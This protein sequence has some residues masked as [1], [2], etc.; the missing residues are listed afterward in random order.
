MRLAAA[1]ASAS[2]TAAR[3]AFSR[4]EG[5][6]RP[7][8]ASSSSPRR[9]IP[10]AAHTRASTG[11]RPSRTSWSCTRKGTRRVVICD[12]SWMTCHPE[13]SEGSAF[14]AHSKADSSGCALRMTSLLSIDRKRFP[15]PPEI[16]QVRTYGL[17]LEQ[18]IH[19]AKLKREHSDPAGLQ[20]GEERPEPVALERSAALAKRRLA[21]SVQNDQRKALV[22][23]RGENGAG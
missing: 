13:R 21:R 20:S 12:I 16:A 9:L 18:R 15:S 5:G 22:P 3:S 23:Q 10:R 6:I 8:S 1:I 19:A 7:E 11:C 4:W 17:D 2:S 14:S